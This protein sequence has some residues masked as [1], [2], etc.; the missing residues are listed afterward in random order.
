MGA[1]LNINHLPGK[2]KVSEHKSAWPSLVGQDVASALEVIK[3][4]R[5]EL[6]IEI[7]EHNTKASADLHTT[8]VRIR[9]DKDGKVSM[10]PMVG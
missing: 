10:V 6:V 2:V 3:T 7:L 5:P 1:L 9:Q 4:E 8:R